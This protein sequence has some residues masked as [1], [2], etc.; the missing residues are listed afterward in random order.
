ME[1]Y[2][3]VG[4]HVGAVG[5]WLGGMLLSSLAMYI[6]TITSAKNNGPS[7][8]L[9]LVLRWNRWITMPAML[10]VWGLGIAMA[11]QIGWYLFTWFKLK[12]M[13]VL[14]LSALQGIQSATL[15]RLSRSTGAQSLS[16]LMRFS[17]PLT[18]VTTIVIIVLVI[19]KPF[20]A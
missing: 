10:V 1:Y 4:L 7:D 12:V 11:L 6:E 2:V 18:L 20:G 3:L 15:R 16:P 17:A 13:L 8:R 5:I 19:A 14:A 9:A